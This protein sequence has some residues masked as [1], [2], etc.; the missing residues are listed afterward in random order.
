MFTKPHAGKTEEAINFYTSIFDQSSVHYIMRYS[1]SDPDVEG[2][3][4]HARFQLNHNPFMAM[5]SSLDHGFTFN[6]GVSLVVQCADQREIDYYW[7]KL[8]QGGE[9]SMCGW[10]RD[11]Y[12]VSWQIVPKALGDM[13]SNPARSQKVM[14]AFL[15]MRKFDLKKLE[16][17]Y[18][19]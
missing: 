15:Q 9:E 10:L 19:E 3:I 2:T 18:T 8:T 7:E 17:A 11:K 4:K 13:M 6:E 5:D 14:E 16:E 1:A 12:G